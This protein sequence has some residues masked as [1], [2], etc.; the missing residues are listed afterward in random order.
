[1]TLHAWVAYEHP[2]EAP[3]HPW[4]ELYT[5]HE[6]LITSFFRSYGGRYTALIAHAVRMET[7]QPFVAEEGSETESYPSILIPRPG[8]VG[9]I[10]R[11]QEEGITGKT[12]FDPW[13]GAEENVVDNL[14][15]HYA[16]FR[17]VMNAEISILADITNKL[18]LE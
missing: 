7:A 1:M 18:L 14:R 6:R 17:Q 16:Q 4:V 8:M 12:F 2:E 10:H 15:Q 11:V 3:V 5:V 9:Y 13:V